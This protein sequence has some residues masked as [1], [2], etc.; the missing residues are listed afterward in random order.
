MAWRLIG[1]LLQVYILKCCLWR[2]LTGPCTCCDVEVLRV[3]RVDLLQSLVN[4]KWV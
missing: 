4:S 1:W 2:V 3:Y